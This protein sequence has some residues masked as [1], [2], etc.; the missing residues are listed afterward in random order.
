MPDFYSL[1]NYGLSQPISFLAFTI[2]TITLATLLVVGILKYK[3]LKTA[4]FGVLVMVFLVVLLT[5]KVSTNSL[6]EYPVTQTPATEK[7]QL[8]ALQTKADKTLKKYGV[9]ADLDISAELTSN[10]NT[11]TSTTKKVFLY[12]TLILGIITMQRFKIKLAK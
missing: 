2:T 8:E 1:L 4:K 9:T 6:V 12:I 7:V 3:S 11:V 10:P 5:V